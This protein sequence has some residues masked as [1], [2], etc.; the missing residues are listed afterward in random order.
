MYVGKYF[1]T[2]PQSKAKT[3]P[4]NYEQKCTWSHSRRIGPVYALAKSY[5]AM[6]KLGTLAFIHEMIKYSLFLHFDATVRCEIFLDLFWIVFFYKG[7]GFCLHSGALCLEKNFW[8]WVSLT[9][10]DS[11]DSWTNLDAQLELYCFVSLFLHILIFGNW[12]WFWI[13]SIK[14]TVKELAKAPNNSVFRSLLSI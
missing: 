4:R 2:T 5:H 9:I 12:K 14:S 11:T 6:C 3:C 8:S 1:I 7:K 10:E 13:L